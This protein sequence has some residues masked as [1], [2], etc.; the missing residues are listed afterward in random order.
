MKNLIKLLP[1]LFC[2]SV[3][4]DTKISQLP[5]TS[6]AS[7][8]GADSI[9]LVN[10]N[11]G[12]TQRITAGDLVNL[13]SLQATFMALVPNQSGQNGKCLQSNGTSTLWGLCSLGSVSS[14]G[15]ADGSTAPIF[16]PSGSPVTS[17]GT[18]TLT[19]AVQNQ[20]KVLVGPSSG[21]DAQPTFRYLVGADLPLPSAS[22]LGG[23]ESKAAVTSQWINS[24]ST[25]GIPTLSQ[26]AF[27]DLAGTVG[28]GQLPT[29]TSVTLG[30]VKSLNAVAQNFLTSI[31][32]AGLPVAAQPA[33][34]DL[35]DA[36]PSC[37]TDATNASNI[38]SGTLPAARLPNPTASTLGGVESLAVIP[39]QFLTGITTSGVPLQAQP[40]CTDLS[41]AAASC[42]S[43]TT[44][45]ANISSGTLP[46]G[47]LPN[48]SAT[49]LGGVQ[50][51]S[52]ITSQW[53]NSISTS[54]VPALSQP[55]FSDISGL[56]TAA[57]M[58]AFSGDI[59]TS[60]G[61]TVTTIAN[62][63]VTNA[64]LAGSIASSKLVGTDINIVGTIA[65]GTW[66]ATPVAIAYG[67]TG[68]TSK[69]AAFDA[70]SPMTTSGDI[71]YGGASG[72]G[73]RLGIGSTGDVLTVSGGG[74]PSWQ[75]PGGGGS[76]V[77]ASAA[78]GSIQSIPLTTDTKVL[79][80]TINVD[81]GSNF[82]SSSFICPDNR[83]Y[84]V[85]AN[86]F[87]PGSFGGY[88]FAWIALNT[89][90][91][92]QGYQFTNTSYSNAVP[93]SGIV[94]CVTS[95]PIDIMT[96]EASAGAQDIGNNLVLTYVDINSIN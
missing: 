15:I 92:R 14:V 47:R 20:N 42:S 76:I 62:G 21:A 44:N 38:S 7:T 55:A 66:N 77:I 64:K 16:V 31:T 90:P 40:A 67:G 1:L 95:Q 71:I 50:S 94:H 27:S 5:L 70:L 61:S 57:Q 36:S 33:C 80:D 11:T 73:T 12:V 96:Y 35:S 28:A 34:T 3:F 45:A 54:G 87:Y 49:T 19:L 32:T 18:L 74:I 39:T 79:F 52:A 26:P 51:K 75:A 53:I 88:I 59:T 78:L 93:V 89:V 2:L 58:P 84:R 22:T 41:D 83:Y 91:I 69:P 25:A 72:T 82:S 46:A 68:Q 56:A 48:P 24:I 85:S 30:G 65:T 23:V 63:V 60:A 10:S 17:T 43:D 81:T 29:P 4:A 13:P 37:A 9:P 8:N 6:A 86:V